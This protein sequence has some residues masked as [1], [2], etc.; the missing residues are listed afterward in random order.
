MTVPQPVYLVRHGQSE[1]N[2]LRITQGQTAHPRLTELGRA[3]AARA[4]AAIASDL[5]DRSV[6]RIISSDLARAADTAQVL[7]ETLDAPITLDT[8]LREQHLGELEGRGYHETWAAADQHDWSDQTLPVAGGE[9]LQDVYDRLVAVLAEMKAEEKRV[10][11]LVSHG[12]AI[13]AAIAHLT[14]HGP[15]KTPWTDVPNGAVARIQGGIAWLG[16]GA[17]FS[18]RPGTVRARPPGCA[19]EPRHAGPGSPPAGGPP[20]PGSR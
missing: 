18:P 9:S 13:R 14:G 11:V 20:G 2:A 12:D 17:P 8:R 1:W 4:G 7:S 15:H 5:T 19:A 6:V 10:T 16:C 3:Q